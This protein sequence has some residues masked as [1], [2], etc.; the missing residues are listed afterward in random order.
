MLLTRSGH[1]GGYTRDLSIHDLHSGL[2]VTPPCRSTRPIN[3]GEILRGQPNL[4]GADIILKV[5]AQLGAGNG[6]RCYP[7]GKRTALLGRLGLY[8]PVRSRRPIHCMPPAHRVSPP[9]RRLG[10]ARLTLQLDLWLKLAADVGYRW[11]GTRCRIVELVA[12]R[13]S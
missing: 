1:S 10:I 5:V 6:K 2:W 9:H 8:R 12:G 7:P 3:L 11:G 4:Q 13:A